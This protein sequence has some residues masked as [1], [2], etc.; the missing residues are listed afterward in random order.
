MVLSLSEGWVQDHFSHPTFLSSLTVPVGLFHGD[1]DNLTPIEGTRNLEAQAKKT[2]K[3]NFEF[4]YF[5]G[6]GHS[7]RISQWFARGTL[8]SGHQVIFDFIKAYTR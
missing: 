8:P 6:L 4:R 1:A 7:L 3:S 5:E 2:E